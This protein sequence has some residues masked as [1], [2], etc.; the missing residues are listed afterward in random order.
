MR[1]WLGKYFERGMD[2]LVKF[3]LR[4]DFARSL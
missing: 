4:R 2:D 1:S 3:G